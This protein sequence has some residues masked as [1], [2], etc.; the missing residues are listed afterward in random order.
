ML[1]SNEVAYHEAVIN[2]VKTV[3]IP[4]AQN[5]QLKSALQGTEPLFEG[6]L[7]HA[8]HVQSAIEGSAKQASR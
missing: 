3:L 6:H 4:S 5:A 8:E 1:P 7:L 2:A